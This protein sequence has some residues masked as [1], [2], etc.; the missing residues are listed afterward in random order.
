MEKE[1]N[2][3]PFRQTQISISIDPLHGSILAFASDEADSRPHTSVIVPTPPFPAY[4][5]DRE[6]GLLLSLLTAYTALQP[7]NH[8][9]LPKFLALSSLQRRDS[10]LVDDKVEGSGQDPGS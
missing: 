2:S 3:W 7:C 1:K 4:E 9:E 8:K 6:H 10:F 5:C